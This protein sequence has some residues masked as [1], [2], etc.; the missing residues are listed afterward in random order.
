M[1]KE[2]IYKKAC[3]CISNIYAD[4]DISVIMAIIDH[5]TDIGQ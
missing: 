1:I 3:M 4:S 2:H 5:I